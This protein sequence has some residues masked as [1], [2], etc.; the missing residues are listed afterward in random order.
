MDWPLTAALGSLAAAVGVVSIGAAVVMRSD[1]PPTKRT[2]AAVV[3]PKPV[4]K[5]AP[6]LASLAPLAPSSAPPLVSPSVPPSVV[7]VAPANYGY[8][9]PFEPP[10]VVVL[11]PDNS[12]NEPV[13]PNNIA[14]PKI[15][16]EPPP[17]AAKPV[18]VTPA[19]VSKP[20]PPPQVH[21]KGVMT[22]SEIA[23]IRSALRL[24][25]EQEPLWRPVEAVLRD[26]GKQQMV[27]IRNGAKPEV[28]SS[29]MSRVYYA[30]QSLLATL[31]PEQKEQVRRLARSMG[32]GSVA[33]ML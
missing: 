3:V 16:H 12:N 31:R 8:E 4:A 27:Q 6:Q 11:P 9:R 14:L 1:A 30:A 17:K 2:S 33:S 24:T 15:K 22:A 23:R 18:V 26:I 32:Y 19:P 10:S 7:I 20:A 13:R 28:D 29:A 21:I 25:H 5:Q